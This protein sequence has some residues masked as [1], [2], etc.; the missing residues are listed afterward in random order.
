MSPRTTGPA[1]GIPQD[2]LPPLPI[3][4]DLWRRV[5]AS[6]KLSRQHALVVENVLRGMS[7]KQIESVMEIRRS[8]LRTYFERIAYRTGLRGRSAIL[9]H[10][11]TLSHQITAQ[12]CPPKG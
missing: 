4:D 6:M 12:G 9:R 8:T 7:D 2:A 1:T 10:I 11:L 5:A 3:P